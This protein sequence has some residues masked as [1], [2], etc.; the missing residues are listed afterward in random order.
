MNALKLTSVQLTSLTPILTPQF[1]TESN[2]D[3][4]VTSLDATDQ[5]RRGDDLPSNGS[6]RTDPIVPRDVGVLHHRQSGGPRTYVTRTASSS[7]LAVRGAVHALS[8]CYSSASVANPSGRRTARTP[9][10]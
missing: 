4:P 7:A 5:A 1:P 2:D 8:S 3:T 9:S 6:D 10:G